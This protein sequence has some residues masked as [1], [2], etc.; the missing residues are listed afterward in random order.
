MF[1]MSPLLLLPI[2]LVNAKQ[3][4]K[5]LFVCWHS[6]G[7]LSRVLSIV[8]RLQTGR[9]R[10]WIPI[11][12][13]CFASSKRPDWLW[14]PPSLLFIGSGVL[15]Q[16]YSS[17]V[18]KLTTHCH[19]VLRLRMS[20]SI[21]LLPH[22]P[23]WCGLGNFTICNTH[24]VVKVGGVVLCYC[25]SRSVI[26]TDRSFSLS[27]SLSP[28]VFYTWITV[29]FVANRFQPLHTDSYDPYTFCTVSCW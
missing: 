29:S 10:V 6:F 28:I 3:I 20:G 23:S 21:P 5:I 2:S 27:L 4:S 11:G 9:S 13:R 24:P 1:I 15:F 25:A 7:S 19:L 18:M 8:T 12:T 26:S 22:I 14:S 16:G 17:W